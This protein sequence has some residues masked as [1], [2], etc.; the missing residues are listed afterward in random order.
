MFT[1]FAKENDDGV[2]AADTKSDAIKADGENS[3]S[4]LE[5]DTAAV[6][7]VTRK[8]KIPTFKDIMA[9][10]DEKLKRKLAPVQNHP[11]HTTC[12]FFYFWD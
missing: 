1:A 11:F 5:D 6:G 3:I 8:K 2:I 9:I 10:A 12:M 7:A 4:T